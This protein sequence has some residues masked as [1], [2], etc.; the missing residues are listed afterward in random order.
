VQRQI[1]EIEYH[2][3]HVPPPRNNVGNAEER[4]V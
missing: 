4:K 1:R 3:E 2:Y